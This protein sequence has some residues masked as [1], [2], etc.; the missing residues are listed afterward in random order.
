MTEFNDARQ[1]WTKESKYNKD[2]EID[3]HTFKIT[4]PVVEQALTL[5]TG[6]GF[7]V[8]EVDWLKSENSIMIIYVKD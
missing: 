8:L 4:M 3:T 5:V 7:E 1:L 6:E 2:G